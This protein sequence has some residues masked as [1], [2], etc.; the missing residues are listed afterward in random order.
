M[1]RRTSG[2]NEWFCTSDPAGSSSI[3]LVLRRRNSVVLDAR[4]GLSEEDVLP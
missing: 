2:R 1:K 3:D 4:A